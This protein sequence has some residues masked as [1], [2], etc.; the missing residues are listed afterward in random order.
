MLAEAQ[1]LAEAFETIV[2][3]AN[4][5]MRLDEHWALQFQTLTDSPDL[6]LAISSVQT[7]LRKIQEAVN[8]SNQTDRA[9]NLYL[10]AISQLE[11]YVNGLKI[12][13]FSVSNVQQLRQQV[14]IL[15]L[16]ADSLNGELIPDINDLTIEALS[17][18]I[19]ELVTEIDNSNL[20]DDLKALVRPALETLLMAVRSYRILGAAGVTRVYGA[21]VAE[22]ARINNI[23]SDAPPEVKSKFRKAL[24]LA[25]K[26]GAAIVWAG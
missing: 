25:K 9:K 2:N 1:E 7:K 23:F 10:S 16:A 3:S 21:A 19:V 15:H 20:P 8:H 11:P 13:Q 26:T 18:E 22:L 14:D 5:N 12:Q 6:L 17:K 4:P 24:E